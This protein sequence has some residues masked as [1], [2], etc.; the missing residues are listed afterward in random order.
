VAHLGYFHAEYVNRRRWLDEA[1]YADLVALCQVL[2]G[3]TSSQLGIAIGALRAGFFGALSAWVGFTLPSAILLTVL[4]LVFHGGLATAS[5]WLHG[6]Q[7]VAVAVVFQAVLT[8]ATRLVR[9]PFLTAVALVS[10]AGALG[11]PGGLTQL[12]VIAGAALAGLVLRRPS[13]PTRLG[14]LEVPYSRRTGVV[15]LVV[16]GALLVAL[17]L[18]RAV[19]GVPLV[20]LAEGL[21]RSGALVFGGGHVVLPLLDQA[22]VAT[23]LVD[24]Q[25]FLAG[26]GAAQAVPGPLFSFGAFVGAEVAGVPGAL[27]GL[28]SLFLPAGLLVLGILPFWN[29][30]QRHPRWAGALETVN[31]GVVGLLGAA[32][33]SP[34][35][36]S[37]LLKPGDAVLAGLFVLA[38]TVGKVPS[39]AVVLGGTLA[40]VLVAA[41]GW[42]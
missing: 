6:L 33:Y 26:Y 25:T 42:I 32:L 9:G 4:A 1:A 40:T 8:M 23:G 28:V 41:W 19:W 20:T 7:L 15:L 31:A 3:P 29:A 21:Y 36:T 30:L 10:L 13:A 14:P 17:P 2:P 37:T 38:L 18:I 22:V 11:F 12:A 39:W 5:P 16:F 34:V 27:V 35:G 24:H